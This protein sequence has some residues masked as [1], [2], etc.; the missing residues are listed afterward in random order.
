MPIRLT[1]SA[2]AG[3]TPRPVVPIRRLPRKRSVTLSITWWYGA[4]MC[5]LAEIRK[6]DAC[7]PRAASPSTS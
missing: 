7:T 5:A 2:Y 4:M 3:P 6:I 1:L